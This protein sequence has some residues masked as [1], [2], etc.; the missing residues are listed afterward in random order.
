MNSNLKQTIFFNNSKIFRKKGFSIFV[1]SCIHLLIR[2]GFPGGSKCSQ[3]S[4]MYVF[5]GWGWRPLN[6][7]PRKIFIYLRQMHA[8]NH[9]LDEYSEIPGQS[10][11]KMLKSCLLLCINT[12]CVTWTWWHCRSAYILVSE[13]PQL[14][15]VSREER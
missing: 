11:T 13:S 9:R 15:A 1:F 4:Y 12:N 3:V 6:L 2:K 10:K 5:R 14:P 8:K 7:D